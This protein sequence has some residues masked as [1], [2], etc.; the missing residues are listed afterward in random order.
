[1]V[2]EIYVSRAK[3]YKN[4]FRNMVYNSDEERDL[5]VGK[6]EDNS[7]ILQQRQELEI[8]ENRVS[9]LIATVSI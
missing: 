9:N 8:F 6:L 4:P 1:M 7:F 3:D 2:D 5:V